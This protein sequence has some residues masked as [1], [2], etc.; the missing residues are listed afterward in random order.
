ME[1]ERLNLFHNKY[2]KSI[3]EIWSSG[4]PDAVKTLKP[5]Y[6]K[7]ETH[8]QYTISWYGK[9]YHQ[10][11]EN[12][13]FMNPEEIFL[14]ARVLQLK[15]QK[16]PKMEDAYIRVVGFLKSL[17]CDFGKIDAEINSVL[18]EKMHFPLFQYPSYITEG[19]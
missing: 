19:Y 1:F 11:Q 18:V 7:G 13:I 5:R 8:Y 12:L 4:I 10:T 2:R 3:E 6:F 9:E 16:H 14:I 17:I 15:A